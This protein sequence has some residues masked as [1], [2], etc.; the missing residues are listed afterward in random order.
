ML[1]EISSAAEGF[2]RSLQNRHSFYETLRFLRTIYQTVTH[3]Q[4]SEPP[5]SWRDGTQRCS[6]Q[7]G[8]LCSGKKSNSHLTEPQAL[9][10]LFRRICL[11]SELVSLPEE[12]G[13]SARSLYEKKL[14]MRDSIRNPGVAANSTLVPELTC[15]DSA[16]QL[17]LSSLNSNSHF[18]STLSNLNQGK[19]LSIFES[20]LGSIQRS[21]ASVNL[22]VL[23][24]RDRN[25]KRF[26]ETWG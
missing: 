13:E 25:Q 12:A 26:I 4:S 8:L 10:S 1:I 22:S 19:R 9:K 6:T 3:V 11:S 14:H 16:N 2:A 5:S 15:T 17:L 21:T 24:Q 20:Q 7:K 18:E 23:Y